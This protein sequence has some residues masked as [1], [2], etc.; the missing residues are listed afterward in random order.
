MDQGKQQWR[1]EL[2]TQELWGWLLV[3]A[4]AGVI[5][6]THGVVGTRAGSKGQRRLCMHWHLQG[7]GWLYALPWLLGITTSVWQWSPPGIGLRAYRYTF[8]GVSAGECPG[9]GQ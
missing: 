3:P 6:N 7:P 4:A 8:G 5:A 2:C 9:A 1:L